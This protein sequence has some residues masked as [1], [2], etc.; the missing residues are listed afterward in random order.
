MCQFEVKIKVYWKCLKTELSF[1]YTRS[2]VWEN[3]SLFFFGCGACIY[4]VNLN[5]NCSMTCFHLNSFCLVLIRLLCR[6]F[7]NCT[8]GLAHFRTSSSLT[9]NDST[10]IANLCLVLSE[11]MQVL[12]ARYSMKKHLGNGACV[13]HD[14]SNRQ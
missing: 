8:G 4:I 1:I 5:R 3:F 10:H 9:P 2:A 13:R 11:N 12:K 7:I 14:I 6:W